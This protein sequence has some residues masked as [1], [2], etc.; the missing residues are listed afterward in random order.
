M[1]E[2][3]A[4]QDQ[5]LIVVLMGFVYYKHTRL[6]FIFALSYRISMLD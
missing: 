6:T 4:A 3:L 1:L 2:V 5:R